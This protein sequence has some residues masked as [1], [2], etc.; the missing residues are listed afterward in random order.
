[1]QAPEFDTN[2]TP[3]GVGSATTTNCASVGPA[4]ATVSTYEMVSPGLATAWPS[5]VIARSADAAF[6]TVVAVA[7]LLP[8]SGS[9]VAAPTVAVLVITPGPAD[10]DGTAKVVWMVRLSPAGIVPRLQG[11]EV[12]Q[13]PLLPTNARPPGVASDTVTPVASPGPLLV[14]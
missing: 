1:M 14:T 10:T 7:V 12:W 9:L 4:F 8:G 3:A 13:S 5:F 2:V 6:T 11:N